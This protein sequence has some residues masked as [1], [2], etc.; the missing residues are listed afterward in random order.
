MFLWG[1]KK[2]ILD[3]DGLGSDPDSAII[4]KVTVDGLFNFSDSQLC[5]KSDNTFFFFFFCLLSF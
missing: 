3:S 1:V 2:V 4:N 5:L